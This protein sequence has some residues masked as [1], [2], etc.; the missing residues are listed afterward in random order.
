M[1]IR[2]LLVGFSWFSNCFRRCIFL[3]VST[4]VYDL[5]SSHMFYTHPNHKLKGHYVVLGK[6]FK[7]RI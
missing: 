3:F 4:F 5:A 7:L 1:I 6:K 2:G